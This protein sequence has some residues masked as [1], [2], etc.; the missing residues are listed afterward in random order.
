MPEYTV[1]QVFVQMRG[2]S[3]ELLFVLENFAGARHRETL[4][5]PTRNTIEAVERAAKHLAYRG[6]VRSVT[7]ARLRREQ[8][9]ELKDDPSL[10][11]MFVNAFETHAENEDDV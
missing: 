5:F 1:D 11:R 3:L 2:G 10:Q 7:G 8:R 9:G 4:A 6:D